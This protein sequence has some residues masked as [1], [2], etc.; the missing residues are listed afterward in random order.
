VAFVVLG[1][2]RRAAAAWDSQFDAAATKAR[3][4][5]DTVAPGMV[6][7]GS[8]TEV[9]RSWAEAARSLDGVDQQLY[10]LQPTAPDA[11]RSARVERA[12]SAVAGLRQSLQTLTERVAGNADASAQ[13]QAAA[14]VDRARTALSAALGEIRPTA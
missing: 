4:L 5:A 2:R 11:E 7:E 3:W 8:A 10:A 12:R 1:R 9:E 6:A 14:E 13:R